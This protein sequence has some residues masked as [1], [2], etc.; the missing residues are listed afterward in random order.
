MV[1]V[2][3]VNGTCGFSGNSDVYGLGI[4]VGYY[5]QALAASFSNFFLLREANALRAVNNLFLF[6]L[7]IVALIYAFHATETYAVEAF[8]LLQI[9]LCVA[10]GSIS[11]STRYST[12][13]IKANKERVLA[14]TFIINAVIILN[15]GFWWIGLDVMLRTPCGTYAC[16]VVQT[17]I[18]GWMRTL[19]KALSL[20]LLLSQTFT[21][22]SHDAA[23]WIQNLYMA[24]A[25]SD[26]VQAA[27]NCRSIESCRPEIP[28]FDQLI[29]GSNAASVRDESCKALGVDSNTITPAESQSSANGQSNPEARSIEARCLSISAEPAPFQSS[30]LSRTQEAHRQINSSPAKPVKFEVEKPS[31]IDNS[32]FEKVHLA[33]KYLEYI[34]AVYPDTAVLGRKRARHIFRGHIKLYLHTFESA[35][36]PGSTPYLKSLWCLIRASWTH[37]PPRSLRYCLRFYL[38]ALQQHNE[39][40]WPRFVDRM[41]QAEKVCT[42]PDWHFLAIAAD[43]QLSQMPLVI[44]PGVWVTMAANTVLINIALIVQVELTIV[45]NRIDGLQNLTT[46]GQIIP[47]VLGVSGLV[48]VLWG[49]WTDIRKGIS[50]KGERENRSKDEYEMAIETYVRWREQRKLHLPGT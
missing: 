49:K 47:F 33:E 32:M 42:P 38:K 48:K 26:F 28:R 3:A 27:R 45:W 16:Y 8:L 46:V 43:I 30:G 12:R 50:E 34:L 25:R 37:H 14:K 21:I 4:R 10:L 31:N 2:S 36:A 11:E 9:A 13:Y 39:W 19:M 44:S 40:R 1:L 23:R 18:Y 17:D 6:A 20:L 7:V 35:C 15:I 24:T 5:T 41:V 22:T 29:N